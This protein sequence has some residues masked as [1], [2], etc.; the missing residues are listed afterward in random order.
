[1]VSTQ[2]THKCDAWLTCC[3]LLEIGTSSW[4]TDLSLTISNLTGWRP[5]ELAVRLKH[6]LIISIALQYILIY[7]IS[8]IVVIQNNLDAYDQ[9]VT[10]FTN[11]IKNIEMLDSYIII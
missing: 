2:N 5:Y 10:R 8:V 3:W 9:M 11:A 7:E 4:R 1:M 6:F